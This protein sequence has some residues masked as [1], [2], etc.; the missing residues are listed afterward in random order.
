L[1]C[2]RAGTSKA[3]GWTD[4]ASLETALRDDLDPKA[5]RASVVLDPLKLR[6]VNFAEVF[7]D[8]AHAEPCHAP[9]HPAHPER[10]QRDFTLT[11]EV[12]IE[13]DDFMEV[14]SKGYFRLVPPHVDASGARRP[15]S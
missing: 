14:P 6:L 4:Y 2:E 12:W 7:G 10:G 1:L 5:A 11:N 15:G 3:G 9:V 13:R 8:L